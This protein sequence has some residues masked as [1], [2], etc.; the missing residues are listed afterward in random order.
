MAEEIGDVERL[1]WV[2]PGG[3]IPGPRK[4]GIGAKRTAH[5]SRAVLEK[6][7]LSPKHRKQQ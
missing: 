3:S 1:L 7:N 2:D 6:A 5:R 4:A